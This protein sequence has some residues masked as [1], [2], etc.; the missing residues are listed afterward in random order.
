MVTIQLKTSDWK[1]RARRHFEQVRPWTEAFLSRR[2]I[3]ASHPIHDFLFVYYQYSPAKLEQWHPGVGFELEV[4]DRPAMDGDMWDERFYTACETGVFCDVRKMNEATIEQL[5]WI[6]RLLQATAERKGN[7]SCLGMHEWAMV[8]RGDEIRHAKTIGLRLPQSEVDAIV[9]TRPITCTHYDAFRFFADDARPLNKHLL[10]LD[11]RMEMEQ[12][13]CIHANMD[14]YKWAYKAM[15]WIGSELL[16]E[17]FELA[18]AAR[19]LDMRASPYDLTRW[20]EYPS[21][22]METSQG[23]AEYEVLQR[24]IAERAAPL[25]ERLCHQLR[26]VLSSVSNDCSLEHAPLERRACLVETEKDLKPH[27]G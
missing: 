23:R 3:G 5:R 20:P 9:E 2:K 24:E 8:Y 15:P 16:R 17:C 11:S 21:I 14:L 4:C 19:A 25:R 18:L 27:R 26:A 22:L 1:E 7:Y 13:A 10:T 12:P 6:A